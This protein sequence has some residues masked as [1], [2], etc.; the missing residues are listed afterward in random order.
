[1]TVKGI[2]ALARVSTGTV[3]RVL[4]NRG[5]VSEETKARV[6]AIVEFYG[7]TPNPIASR[8]KR[9]KPYRFCAFM[10]GR[11]QD[12]GYWGQILLGIEKE[13]AEAAALGV[14]TT[15][16]EYDRYN[17]AE[18]RRRAKQVLDAEYDGVMFAPITPAL[19]R[20]FLKKL[21]GR[22]LPLVFFDTDLPGFKP[23]SVIGP[24]SRRGGYLAGR[25]MHLFV[26]NKK[27]QFAVLD[28]HE[29][30]HNLILRRDGFLRYAREHKFP[31]FSKEYG[32]R[33]LE[34]SEKE[35]GDFLDEHPDLG[36]IFIPNSMAHLVAAQKKRE[37]KRFLIIGFDLI[38]VNLQLLSEGG[39]DVIIDQ[40]PV[41]QGQEAMRTL[42]RRIVL[43]QEVPAKIDIPLDIYIREN[44]PPSAGPSGRQ[45]ENKFTGA[46]A[47]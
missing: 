25:I 12:A 42:Y 17:S 35:I 4:Y 7:F 31:A 45:G 22:N 30:D 11:D 24:D 1:M 21:T 8:L 46:R 43:Q 37:K 5:R 10:P 20:P 14:E 19:T 2:A 6:R 27:K 15:I 39:I 34:M 36:G 26:K 18:F 28:A 13:S 16:V 29:C 41:L 33:R 23:L 9:G 47:R 3:D 32:S 40:R 38:P 44:A